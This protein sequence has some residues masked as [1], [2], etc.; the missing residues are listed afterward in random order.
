M[1]RRSG[2]KWPDQQ[3]TSTCISNF[4]NW[5]GKNQREVIYCLM[6]LLS[7]HGCFL[8]HHPVGYNKR[9]DHVLNDLEHIFV[10]S[11]RCETDYSHIITFVRTTDG[12]GKKFIIKK[13]LQVKVGNYCERALQRKEI[14]AAIDLTGSRIN[15]VLMRNSKLNRFA[16]DLWQYKTHLQYCLF[17]VPWRIMF[18]K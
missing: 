8:E 17:I 16:K 9:T 10:L 11:I 4:W 13:F 2:V 15:E 18:P 14:N 12:I 7:G 6:K 3:D 1:K 5:R